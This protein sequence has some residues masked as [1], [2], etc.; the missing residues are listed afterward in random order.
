MPVHLSRTAF[1]QTAGSCGSSRIPTPQHTHT[2]GVSTTAAGSPCALSATPLSILH[3]LLSPAAR[4]TTGLVE[5]VLIITGTRSAST[6]FQIN[7]LK[8]WDG[9]YNHAQRTIWGRKINREAGGMGL[10]MINVNTH[11][12]LIWPVYQLS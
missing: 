5:A 2:F 9:L 7:L 4:L 6:F 1:K 10:V 8:T 3:M 11:T 12:P